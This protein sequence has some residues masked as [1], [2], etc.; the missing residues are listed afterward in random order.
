MGM[1]LILLSLLICVVKSE[2]VLLKEQGPILGDSTVNLGLSLYQTMIKD[3]KLRSQNLLFSPV[4][5]ASSLG[6]MSMGAKD[7]T[8]K[9]VKSLLNINL[10]DDTLHSAFSELLNE[11]SNETARNTTWKIGNCLYAPTSVNVRDDFVQKTKTH[12]KYDHSQINFKDQRSALRSI[13][14][15]AS[16]ATEGKLSEITAALSST[17]GAFIINANY[18]KP[19]WDESFQQTMVDKRGFII[20][21]THTVS[22]PMMHQ[23][24]LCNYYEDNANSLQVLELPL[25]HKHSSM[26]FIMTKHIEPLARLEKLL[27]KE[28]LN[29]W[30]G[31]LERHTVS[32][33]LPKVNLEVSHDLQKYLQELGLTEAVDKNKADFSGITGKKNLHLSGMLHATAIDWDT[34]G[35]QFDQDWNSP[36]I[37]KSAKVFYADHAYIFLI[38]DNKTNSILLI[39]RLVKPKSNDHDEL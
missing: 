7:K 38:R 18:F 5:V 21:R 31:K 29:T 32:I 35:N 34:E 27:T 30:I 25:S 22:I 16:Q 8:A 20:T 19:H 23:I 1:K 17:D 39:G 10:N 14:Q 24:R 11:V 37:T 2:P 3:Q 26:I 4:V 15:W 28:Q 6:V 13:N 9:Q 33:S 36:E 12:Y